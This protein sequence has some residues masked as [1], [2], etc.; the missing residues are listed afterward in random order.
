MTISQQIVQDSC[1][2]KWTYKSTPF[3]SANLLLRREPAAAF[4]FHSASRTAGSSA[5]NA[6]SSGHRSAAVGFAVVVLL[7][8]AFP[9][10]SS[11]QQ[12][13]QTKMMTGE[14]RCYDTWTRLYSSD[15]WNSIFS[16]QDPFRLPP[17]APAPK[18]LGDTNAYVEQV[19]RDQC[20]NGLYLRRLL[21]WL[22]HLRAR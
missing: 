18:L 7:S 16:I 2:A 13:H 11:T 19:I 20:E 9:L 15:V 8:S 14:R 10:K 22:G 6:A 17:I 4:A 21:G 5:A 1:G 3:R 12:T